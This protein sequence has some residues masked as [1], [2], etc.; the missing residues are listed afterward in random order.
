MSRKHEI[1]RDDDRQVVTVFGG[2]LTDCLNVGAEVAALPGEA[3]VVGLN[4]FGGGAHEVGEEA[5]PM[6]AE[7]FSADLVEGDLLRGMPDRRGDRN[8]RWARLG[9]GNGPLQ[10]L[11]AAHRAAGQGQ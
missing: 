7:F 11:H 4:R 5:G 3:H 6:D 9:I 8:Q 1:E 10:R 2:K